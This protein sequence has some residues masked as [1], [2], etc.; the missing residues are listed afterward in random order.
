MPRIN[1]RVNYS[2]VRKQVEKDTTP[3]MLEYG[4][5]IVRERVDAAQDIMLNDF[6]NHPVTMEI[7]SKG[8]LGNISNTILGNGNLFGFIGFNRDD[9]PIIPLRTALSRTFRI[10][11][12]NLRNLNFRYRIE[13]PSV[14]LL[15]RFT[16]IPWA[17][18]MSWITAVEE[19]LPNI[20][21]Y[22][23]IESNVS[24]SEEG[25]QFSKASLGKKYLP[26]EYL[27]PLLEK[28]ID[29][30]GNSPYKNGKFT[31]LGE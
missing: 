14:L 29:N 7:E 18:G 1:F 10:Y 24:R 15:E 12:I 26:T 19:G 21:K 2:T 23:Y 6:N 27:T 8:E 4:R 5:S 9:E 25:I 17:T 13:V 11:K 3:K 30:I 16:P 20:G 22:A 28:F 31:R